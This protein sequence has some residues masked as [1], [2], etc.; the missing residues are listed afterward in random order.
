MFVKGLVVGPV[1]TNCYIL[2]DEA[3]KDAALIDPGDYGR[4]VVTQAEEAGYQVTMILL[5]HGHFDHIGGVQ[6]ALSALKMDHPDREIPVYIHRADYPKAPSS[7]FRP[8]SLEGVEGIRFYD[9]GDTVTLGSHTIR[10][11]STPGHTQGG[12]CLM[13]EDCLFTGDTLFAGACGRTDF[14]TSSTADMMA[15]LKRLGQL[16]GDYKVYPGHEG[17]TLLS[18]ER[19]ENPYLMYAMRNAHIF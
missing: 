8:V 16:E 13:V 17:A 18:V 12:V 7:F 5:T 3:T 19:Q 11:L 9:E 10:V 2:G 14:E 6:A 4:W 15:S 1:E